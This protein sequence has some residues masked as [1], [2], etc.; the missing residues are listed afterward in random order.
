MNKPL[1]R[2]L[3]TPDPDR[4][5]ERAAEAMEQQRQMEYLETCNKLELKS[6]EVSKASKALNQLKLEEEALRVQR[7]Q[8]RKRIMGDGPD[9]NPEKG[10]P[11][12]VY[13]YGHRGSGRFA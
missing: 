13:P 6:L 1:E 5:A 10:K 7:E 11:A 4:S 9:Q 2:E 8:Q 12:P 3:G